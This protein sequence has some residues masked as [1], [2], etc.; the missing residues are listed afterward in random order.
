MEHLLQVP[1]CRQPLFSHKNGEDQG[2]HFLLPIA[3]VS[4]R[5][6]SPIIW[7]GFPMVNS[8]RFQ[9]VFTTLSTFNCLRR[10]KCNTSCTPPFPPSYPF[11][12]PADEAQ[13]GQKSLC[14]LIN[15]GVLSILRGFPKS[16]CSL[17]YK[18]KASDM[19]WNQI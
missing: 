16:N 3:Q 2:I 5:G 13:E 12:R 4:L 6:H 14:Y 9:R 7:V 8:S 19:T 18:Y 1:K 15:P 11:V 10:V 17:S